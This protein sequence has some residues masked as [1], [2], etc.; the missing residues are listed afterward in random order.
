MWIDL[1]ADRQGTTVRH[2]SPLDR[3][4]LKTAAADFLPSCC[5]RILQIGT[6]PDGKKCNLGDFSF[7]PD[8]RVPHCTCPGEEHPADLYTMTERSWAGLLSRSM[9]SKLRFMV[10]RVWFFSL[11]SGRRSM[12][13]SSGS[14]Q[15]RIS[16]FQT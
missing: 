3:C 15:R 9:F 14:T 10:V 11:V 5:R 16:S 13:V 4:R 6:E 7:L 2:P 1:I 8:Q 12:W